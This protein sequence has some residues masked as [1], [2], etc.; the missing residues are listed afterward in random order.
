MI[1]S[2]FDRLYIY[3]KVT[4]I[5]YLFVA[6]NSLIISI[7]DWNYLNYNTVYWS[8]WNSFQKNIFTTIFP[9]L[10]RTR[11]NCFLS[12]NC[13]KPGVWINSLTIIHKL[14]IVFNGTNLLCIILL[15]IEFN[16]LLFDW[17]TSVLWHILWLKS[18]LRELPSHHY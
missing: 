10:F 13:P 17:N 18:I 3:D 14:L 4:K 1:T 6:T 5:K 15:I 8:I 12:S 7:I 9:K 11:I 2:A 16:K